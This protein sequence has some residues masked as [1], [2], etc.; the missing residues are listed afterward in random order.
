MNEWKSSPDHPGYRVKTI[1][2]GACTVQIL[3]PILEREE[4]A[5]RE[6]HVKS[7]VERAIKGYIQRK[8]RAR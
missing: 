1:K 7:V 6:A 5:K 2:R 8:E 3:R 4:A